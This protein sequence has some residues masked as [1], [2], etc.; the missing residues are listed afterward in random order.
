MEHMSTDD[1]AQ[2]QWVAAITRWYYTS[3]RDWIIRNLRDGV[4]LSAPNSKFL[5][6]ILD[7][8]VKPLSGKQGTSARLHN[9]V[10]ARAI[11]ELRA[12]G[13]TRA[14]ILT[15]LK[16]RGLFDSHTA[17]SALNKRIDGPYKCPV[18]QRMK[19]DKQLAAIYARVTGM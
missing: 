12:Q 4:P 1:E 13:M 11:D 5:A 19:L 9:N 17:V 6:A 2:A 3:K 7:G 16:K 8:D 15:A 18:Q 10:I 14:D